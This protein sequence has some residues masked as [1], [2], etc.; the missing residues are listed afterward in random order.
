MALLSLPSW[1]KATKRKP[2]IIAL[3][4]TSILACAARPAYAG[5]GKVL[6]PTAK[7][8]GYTLDDMAE[9]L[10]YFT[11]SGN[12]LD[13]YPDT[14]FQILYV[15]LNTGTNTFNVTAG[16]RFFVPIAFADDSPPIFGDFPADSSTVEA[17]VFGPDQLGAHDLAI[18]VDGV[19]T[20]I[21]PDYLA[22]P[23]LAPG[24]L[25][26]GGSH[27]IQIGAFLTPLSNG[28]HTITIRG[29]FDGAALGDFGGSFEI[30]YTL[31]VTS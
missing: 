31:N 17:Y 21:G 4:L 29:T 24:L 20:A 25:D 15:D 2:G 10:A 7:P 13:F 22:G 28:S 26:G 14:P 11:T 19:S 1:L 5:G 12:D 16:T 23:V 8:S 30:S 18:D 3:A 6:P 27:F 9:E